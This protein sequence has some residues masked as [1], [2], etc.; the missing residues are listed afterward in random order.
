MNALSVAI[1]GGIALLLFVTAFVRVGTWS[2]RQFN[3]VAD[4]AAFAIA[5]TAVA[6][7]RWAFF[8]P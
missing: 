6:A 8:T 5:A 2:Q 1:P 4:V 3:A 7:V